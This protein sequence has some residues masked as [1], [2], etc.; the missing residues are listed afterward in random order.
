MMQPKEKMSILEL[1]TCFSMISGA[2]YRG[3]PL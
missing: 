2:M 3:V 1:P